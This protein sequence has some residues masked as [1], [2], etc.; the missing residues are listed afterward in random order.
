MTQTFHAPRQ[1]PSSL[2]CGFCGHALSPSER[3]QIPRV[4]FG[5]GAPGWRGRCPRC[6][7]PVA[8]RDTTGQKLQSGRTEGQT[9]EQALLQL[10]ATRDGYQITWAETADATGMTQKRLNQ[11]KKGAEATREEC[12]ALANLVTVL[13]ALKTV[14]GTN[15]ARYWLLARVR[16]LGG[17]RPVKVLPG[18]YEAV[19]EAAKLYHRYGP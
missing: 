1:A 11:L 17:R 5:S 15:E 8:L 9:T 18:E 14:P 4:V 7:K 10:I 3:Q 12:E 2:R 16:A 13:K 19:L 6:G